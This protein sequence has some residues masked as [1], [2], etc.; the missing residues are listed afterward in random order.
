VSVG[1]HLLELVSQYGFSDHVTPDAAKIRFE[2]S[3][4]SLGAAASLRPYQIFIGM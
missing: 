4:G 2:E 1:V 3:P